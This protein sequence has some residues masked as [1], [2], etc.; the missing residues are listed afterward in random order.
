MKGVKSSKENGEDSR[1]RYSWIQFLCTSSVWQNIE[2]TSQCYDIS[3]H[4]FM[5][6]ECSSNLNSARALMMQLCLPCNQVYI[7][8]LQRYYHYMTSIDQNLQL[9]IYF[10]K[11]CIF[12]RP[13]WYLSP[14]C[15]PEIGLISYLSPNFCFAVFLSSLIQN[16]SCTRN[17]DPTIYLLHRH[18][19][20]Q[21]Q[22]ES[23]FTFYLTW[24]R[25][26][27]V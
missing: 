6:Q 27:K 15:Y 3:V 2:L 12:L 7:Q 19:Q 13:F 21:A 9:N 23:V 18:K 1:T 17:E 8:I 25:S 5:A 10:D 20:K 16:A 26:A 22:T 14:F 24:A 4:K 11:E